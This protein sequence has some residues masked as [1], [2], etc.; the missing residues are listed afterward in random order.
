MSRHTPGFVPI[1]QVVNSFMN[2]TGI[3]S[4][5]NRRRFLKIVAENY[6][7]L[8]IHS[9]SLF[10]TVFMTIDSK[11]C[12]EWPQ[13]YVD[14]VRIG[15]PYNGQIQALTLNDKI[16][17][18]IVLVCGEETQDPDMINPVNQPWIHAYG[19]SGGGNFMYYRSD[20]ETHRIIFE[21]DGVGRAIVLQ[22]ISSG[23]SADGQTLIPFAMVK[24]L[25][26]YL[27]WVVMDFDM[28]T[29]HSQ[30]EIMRVHRD[31]VQFREEYERLDN[32][33]TADEFIDALRQ[34]YKLTPKN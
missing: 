30:S 24:L 12:I 19:S 5:A 31:F 9:T 27:Q 20:K 11:N 34:S 7:D 29:K 14:Y 33:F 1:V 26:K 4:P 17:G 23:V 16:T 32:G 2:A 21:G 18:N 8:N 13:D 10:K 25:R 22:Y 3:Y 28:V 6:A 15:T